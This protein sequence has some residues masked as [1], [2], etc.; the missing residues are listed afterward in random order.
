MY[1]RIFTNLLLIC[2]LTKTVS[3]GDFQCNP[4]VADFATSELITDVK[5]YC[6]TTPCIYKNCPPNSVYFQTNGALECKTFEDISKLSHGTVN[7]SSLEIVYKFIESRSEILP[8]H[9]KITSD[10]KFLN[11]INITN[12]NCELG[13]YTVSDEDSTYYLLEDGSILIDCPNFSPR[14]SIVPVGGY[15]FELVI[16]ES[17]GSFSDPIFIIK[18]IEEVSLDAY[19][20]TYVN[21]IGMLISSFFMILFLIVFSVLHRTRTLAN[22]ILMTY[23]ACLLVSFLLMATHLLVRVLINF[24]YF[25]EITSVIQYFATLSSFFWMNVIAFDIFGQLAILF[26]TFRANYKL[27]PTN[28]RGITHKYRMYCLFAFGIP[29]LMTVTALFIDL[30]DLS[31]ERDIVK[32]D[33][34][35]CLGGYGSVNLYL[36]TPITILIAINVILF[37][38]TVFNIWRVRSALHCTGDISVKRNENRFTVY[39]KLSLI[40]GVHWILDIIATFVNI[41]Q[42]LEYISSI[43]NVSIGVIIFILYV[44]KKQYLVDICK[45]YSIGARFIKH[46]DRTKSHNSAGISRTGTEKSNVPTDQTDDGNVALTKTEISQKP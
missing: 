38:L 14:Y 18:S 17:N 43:Y 34:K 30:V 12:S 13:S 9:K 32:I 25:C 5:E 40:T 19:I 23:V 6:K 4:T 31:T 44:C 37:L 41:P 3:S 15:V 39:F 7:F 26:R 29:F 42:W 24:T 20:T 8:S 27:H 11:L 36:Y 46:I 45:R 10:F 2:V 33:F 16:S 1:T 35:S 22:Q 21:G 28:R